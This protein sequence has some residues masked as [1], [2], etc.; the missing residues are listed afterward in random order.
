MDPKFAGKPLPVTQYHSGDRK[1]LDRMSETP[2]DLLTI[3]GPNRKPSSPSPT[4]T[5]S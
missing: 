4:K 3:A 2:V 1:H 5:S